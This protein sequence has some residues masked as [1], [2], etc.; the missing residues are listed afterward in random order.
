MTL[1]GDPPFPTCTSDCGCKASIIEPDNTPLQEQV[2][3]PNPQT[4]DWSYLDEIDTKGYYPVSIGI[5]LQEQVEQVEDSLR[6]ALNVIEAF[7]AL[8]KELRND[9]YQAQLDAQDWMNKYVRTRD[10]CNDYFNRLGNQSDSIRDLLAEKETWEKAFLMTGEEGTEIIGELRHDLENF[11]ARVF[12]L[13]NLNAELEVR[14]DRQANMILD[15]RK[16]LYRSN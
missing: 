4:G 3:C 14:N 13:T 15:A 11:R 8:E 5:S 6:K 10:L 7:V 2:E 12:E 16:A 1:L 9:V